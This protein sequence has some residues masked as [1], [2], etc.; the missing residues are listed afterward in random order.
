M[1]K[2]TRIEKGWGYELWVA[3]NE[4]YC[5]K[6]LHVEDGKKCSMHFHVKKHETFYI[7]RGCVIMRL[8][9]K[10]G[11]PLKLEMKEGNTLTVPQGLM[12][13]FEG[14]G[15]ADIME[16]STTHDDMDSYRIERGD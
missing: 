13:Q 12:H 7:V 1:K 5:G 6:I 11:T 14:I 8:I 4:N 15:D 9:L 10:D 3:N 2:P 16:V